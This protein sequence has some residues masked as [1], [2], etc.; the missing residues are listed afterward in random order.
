MEIGG[1]FE[2]E[3]LIHNEYY[4]DLIAL[5][6]A[7]NAVAYLIKTKEIKKL[8]IPTYLCDSIKKICDRK[9]CLYDF[10]EVASDFQPI[11]RIRCR[12]MNGYIL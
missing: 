5:N 9:G 4:A 7:R 8:Y 2:F 3:N 10:Y 6:T 12:I 11:L 1:Y